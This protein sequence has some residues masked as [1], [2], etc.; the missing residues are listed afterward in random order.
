MR[1]TCQ[2]TK[3]RKYPDGIAEETMAA[4]KR[5][6]IVGAGIGGVTLAIALRE[7][8][9]DA[10][11]VEIEARVVGVGITLTGTTLRALDMLGLAAG[12]VERGFGFDYFKVGDGAGN[13]QATN[14]L[15]P[16]RPGF[17]AAIGMQRP[18]F[19]DF[20]AKTATGNGASIREGL[21]VE[22]MK[23][24][25][26]RVDVRFTD[27]TTGRYD[28][29]VGADGVFSGIRKQIYGDAYEP[30][31]VG[32]GVYRF[33]TDRHP[34]IDQIV[35]FVGPKLKAGFIP[36]SEDS[37]YL[38]TTMSYPPHTRIDE[39]KTHVILKEALKDF[40]APIVIEVRERMR[41]PE[42]VVWRPFENTLVPSPWYKGRVVLIGDAAHTM[43]P[44]LTAGGGMAIEDVVILAEALAQDLTVSAALDNFM[45]RRF[46]RVRAACDISLEICK[47]EQAPEP[48][49]AK[50]YSLT[51]Q[52]Y[53]LLGKSF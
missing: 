21:T 1:A 31:Y 20:M 47:L 16:S 30:T 11:V 10:D 6:L 9:I 13:I 43:T 37:M 12:C 40:T 22:S 28:L 51:G 26:D 41:S 19:A 48:D 7:R 38:F 53:A 44:H 2:S 49:V 25:A 4:V 3:N 18:V 27:G 23:Q 14:P 5:V 52:G 24:D 17:P 32:Q 39:S 34:S 46:E 33:M 42:R 50:I 15:P 29:V 45:K 35:V 36:L 8:G